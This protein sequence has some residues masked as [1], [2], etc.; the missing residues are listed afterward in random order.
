MRSPEELATTEA[1]RSS[2]VPQM[3]FSRLRD[4]LADE[5]VQQV[6]IVIGVGR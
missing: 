1:D 5:A 4:F 2:V 6:V 3:A